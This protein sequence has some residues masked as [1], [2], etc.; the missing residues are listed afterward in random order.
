MICMTSFKT[1]NGNEKIETGKILDI[2]GKDITGGMIISMVMT[3]MTVAVS[4]ALY[5]MH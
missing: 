3:A 5:G 4:C 1:G 2:L